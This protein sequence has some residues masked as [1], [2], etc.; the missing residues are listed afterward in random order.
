MSATKV[1]EREILEDIAAA[2]RE[3]LRAKPQDSAYADALRHHLDEL[4]D[5]RRQEAGAL[6]QAAE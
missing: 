1:T 2:A 5:W 6:M 3:L 4:D